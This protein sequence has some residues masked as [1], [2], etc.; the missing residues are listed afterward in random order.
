MV[1]LKGSC[2]VLIPDTDNS[3]GG[4]FTVECVPVSTNHEIYHHDNLDIK[5]HL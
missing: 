5:H 2:C 4:R 1:M 3:C